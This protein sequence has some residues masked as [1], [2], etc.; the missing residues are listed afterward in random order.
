MKRL[1]YLLFLISYC[2][3]T[4]QAGV[5]EAEDLAQA[6]SYLNTLRFRAGMKPFSTHLSLETAAFNHANYLA[7][8]SLT[9]HGEIE[10]LP[11]FTGSSARDRA[12]FASYRSLLV[13][14]NVSAGNVNSIDSIDSLMSAIY[15][16]LGFLDFVNNEVGIGIA[17]TS[18]TNPNAHSVYVYNMGNTDYNALCQGDNF[19]GIGGYYVGVCEPEIRLEANA[20][21]NVEISAMG[22]NPNVVVWPVDGDDDVPPAFFE[23]TPDPLPDYSV[24]GYPISL[25]FNPLT[26][27]NVNLIEFKLYRQ[28]DNTEI[29]STRLLTHHTDPNGKLSEL[30]YALFPLQRLAWNT[31]YQ[32]QVSYTTDTGSEQLNWQFQTRDLGVPVFTLSEETKLISIPVETSSLAIYVPPTTSS[33]QIGGVNYRYASGMTVETAFIDGNTLQIDLQ[34]QVGQEVQMTLANGQ[35][36]TIRLIAQTT[37]GEDEQSVSVECQ[38]MTLSAS[39]MT[40]Q[41]PTIIF[42][43]APTQEM[44]LWA[45]LELKANLLYQLADFGFKKVTA[46]AVREQ[47]CE[48][49][50]LSPEIKLHIP[51]LEYTTLF[52]IKADLWVDL[53]LVDKSSFKVVDFGFK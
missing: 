38:P 31:A 1:F 8:N 51:R 18:L 37:N 49:A 20:F 45:R 7:D 22:K 2:Y 21:K 25:Q 28:A 4:V 3:T 32:M 53:E 11:G 23:E 42:T 27:S 43:P 15:H 30:E 17:K 33:P 29:Q 50:T 5:F 12:I 34:G 16:R 26:Y 48:F 35:T 46:Q 24:S 40:I 47:G 6:Y 52:N 41:I 19:S 9:G 39:A 10:G 13:T 44:V 36:F 14:E